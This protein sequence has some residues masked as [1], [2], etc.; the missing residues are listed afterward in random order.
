VERTWGG[1]LPALDAQSSS[2]DNP[3][4]APPLLCTLPRGRR[5]ED[6]VKRDGR[7]YHAICV[8]M[9]EATRSRHHVM[10]QVRP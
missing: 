6:I 1:A 4:D 2:T 7:T 5:H 10:L 3:A 9:L 8:A